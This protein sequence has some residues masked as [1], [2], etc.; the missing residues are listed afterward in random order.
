MLDAPVSGGV[1]GAVAG[2][3]AV[4]VS[5]DE[6]TYERCR[7]VLDAIGDKAQYCGSIGCGD[8]MQAGAQCD[9]LCVHGGGG[10]V[11]HRGGEG[12]GET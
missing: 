10:R 2:R 5:G 11:F 12:W 9:Q 3:L 8:D 1:P 4:M 7:P 6:E